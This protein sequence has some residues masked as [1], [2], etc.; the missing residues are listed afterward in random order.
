MNDAGQPDLLHADIRDK[1]ARLRRALTSRLAVEGAAWTVVAL[2][3]LVFGTLALDYLLRLERPLRAAIML[4]A[5]ASV[6]W[7]LWRSLIQ[8]LRVPMRPTDLAMLVEN[9]FDV[10]GDRLV[11]AVFFSGRTEAETF[12]ASPAM[13]AHMADEANRL[14]RPLEFGQVVERRGIFRSWAVAGCALT[15]LLGFGI[16]QGDLLNRWFK[17]NVLLADVPWPQATYIHILG[18]GDFIVMRGDDLKVVI[19]VE[20]RSLVVPKEVELHATYAGIGRTE[21]RLEPDADN[22]RRFVKV[23]PAVPEE[24]EFYVVG[25]DDRRDAR[26]PHRVLL[27]DPPSFRKV[28]FT[29][30]RPNYTNM[31]RPD[32]YDGSAGVLS[33]PAG[34]RVTVEALANKP[35]SS[36]AVELD[37]NVA[38]QLK[39]RSAPAMPDAAAGSAEQADM[40]FIGEFELPPVNK[41]ESRVLRFAL[42]DAAGHVNRGGAK[43]LLQVQPDHAPTVE[44]RKAAVG[45]RISPRAILPLHIIARDEYGLASLAVRLGR[46]DKPADANSIAVVLPP[47][48][49]READIWRELDIEPLK[50]KPNETIYVSA[51]A[52]D[53]MPA[54]FGGPNRG[55]S[56]AMSFMIVKPEDLMEEFVR[57]QKELRLEFIQAMALQEAG[58]ARTSV[59]LAIFASGKVDPESRR[60]LL[61]SASAQASVGAE[62]AKAGDMLGAIVEEMK[63]NRVG[64]DTEREQIRS[65][66]V[67]PLEDLQEPVR[68]IL[69][70]LHAT[71]EVKD[72]GDLLGQARRIEE[73]QKDVLARMDE[74]LQQ[75]AK[76]E[77]KQEMANK[78]Q[79]IIQWSQELLDTIK[80]KQEAETGTVFEPATKPAGPEN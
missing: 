70:A 33:V 57:R 63:Y 53:T 51:C 65:G 75:M 39:A 44:L 62:I 64:T 36:A 17:R 78:L 21:Q 69:A 41:A 40:W 5:L 3:A 15:L 50:F 77:S 22:P 1:L 7:V 6:A 55:V 10:L 27:I 31:P 8:P 76:L 26:R 72:A 49:G 74:I 67:Q 23:F 79:L 12:G 19:D 30:T 20:P 60:E 80:K 29:I 4:M 25:G 54:T 37:G 32:A 56:G 61:G 28:R 46:N 24:F 73:L 9:R 14:A 59:A 71:R 18:E 35:L 11:S 38:G 13:V 58:R 2:V 52:D 48:T 42:A 68:R 16:L 47:D 43:Y 45:A 66:V 34:S